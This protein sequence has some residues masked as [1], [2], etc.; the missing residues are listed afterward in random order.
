MFEL[1]LAEE[2][3]LTVV[4]TAAV[5]DFPEVEA[6]FI[7]DLHTQDQDVRLYF[8]DPEPLRLIRRATLALLR[9]AQ[10][11][12]P[13]DSVVSLAFT[14]SHPTKV[15]HAQIDFTLAEDLPY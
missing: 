2:M 9:H 15:S 13:V 10:R 8:C 1:D 11:S 5:A 6:R 12:Y 3:P 4:A 14:R 7:L